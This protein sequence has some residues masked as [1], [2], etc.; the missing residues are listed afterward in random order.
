MIQDGTTH[1]ILK[2]HESNVKSRLRENTTK[3]G[4]KS[5]EIVKNL[6]IL[7]GCWKVYKNNFS[8]FQLKLIEK[9]LKFL[10]T[11]ILDLKQKEKLILAKIVIILQSWKSFWVIF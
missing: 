7:F 10:D 4:I 9:R 5:N 3:N 6:K 11:Q 2:N 8:K 1:T